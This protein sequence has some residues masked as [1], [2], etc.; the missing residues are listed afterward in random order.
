MD[1]KAIAG[2]SK[3][4]IRAIRRGNRVSAWPNAATAS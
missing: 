3:K 1:A 2:Q 4:D